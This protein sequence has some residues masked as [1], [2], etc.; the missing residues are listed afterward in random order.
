MVGSTTN[1]DMA[2]IGEGQD[3]AL[4]D[5]H[6]TVRPLSCEAIATV[7]VYLSSALVTVTA[8]KSN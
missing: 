4:T 7:T 5:E 1:G 6:R 8:P 3:A 2:A